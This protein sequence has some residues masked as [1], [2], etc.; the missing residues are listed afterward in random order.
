LY[1]YWILIF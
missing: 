1:V